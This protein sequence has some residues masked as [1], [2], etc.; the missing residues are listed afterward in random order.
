MLNFKPETIFSGSNLVMKS[1]V[2]IIQK[3]LFCHQPFHWTW[4]SLR[5]IYPHPADHVI[6]CRSTTHV[7]WVVL[8]SVIYLDLTLNSFIWIYYNKYIIYIFKYIIVDSPVNHVEMYSRLLSCNQVIVSSFQPNHMPHRS[9]VWI[10]PWRGWVPSGVH[11]RPRT[12]I[13][14]SRTLFFTANIL[15]TLLSPT[16]KPG[17]LVLRWNTFILKIDAF[18]NYFRLYYNPSGINQLEIFMIDELEVQF[19]NSILS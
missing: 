6:I 13:L 15:L 2:Q 16:F 12:V 5:N 10:R 8:A 11:S 9:A 1:P 19:Q 17:V 3:A 4:I 7:E 18:E 14:V